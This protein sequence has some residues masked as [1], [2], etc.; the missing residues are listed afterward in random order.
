MR[1]L[2]LFDDIDPKENA[3]KFMNMT[4]LDLYNFLC[5]QAN[6]IHNVGKFDWQSQVIVH[7]ADT[8]EESQCDTLYI[9]GDDGNEL[10]VLAT[11]LE[12]VFK[13]D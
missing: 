2:M 1:Q 8:G 5:S 11:H 12:T 9:T 3:G 10:L 6:D 4:W 7:N 13:S